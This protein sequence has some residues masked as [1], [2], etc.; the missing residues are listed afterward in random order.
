MRIVQRR[1]PTAELRDDFTGGWAG[2]LDELG[3]VVAERGEAR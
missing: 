3:R 1:F 2:I